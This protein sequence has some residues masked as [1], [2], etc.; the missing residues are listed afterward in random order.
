ML[1]IAYK[2]NPGRLKIFTTPWSPPAWMRS[3]K[4]L[5]G[6]GGYLRPECYS[7]YADYFVK[8]VKEYESKGTP[9]Y[10]VTIQNEPQYAPDAYPGMKMSIQDHSL[11]H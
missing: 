10:A 4:G 6:N 3:N 1:D 7:I 9:V 8:Y 2:V 5:F 11:R